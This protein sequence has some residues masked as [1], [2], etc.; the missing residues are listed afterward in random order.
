MVFVYNDVEVLWT[1]IYFCGPGLELLLSGSP[2][3][4]VNF[5]V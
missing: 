3:N 1:A 4:C 5:C 2:S